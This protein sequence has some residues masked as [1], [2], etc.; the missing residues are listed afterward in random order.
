MAEPLNACLP[1]TNELDH[2]SNSTKLPFVL[3][4][5]GGCSFEDK[6][7]RAQTA[8]F[9]AAIIYDNVF[10]DLVASNGFSTGNFSAAVLFLSFFLNLILIMESFVAL[11]MPRVL[12][13]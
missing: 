5:R 7:R 10:S 3:I 11:V 8:G 4:I 2:V 1:L 13:Y 9:K 6:I 12:I